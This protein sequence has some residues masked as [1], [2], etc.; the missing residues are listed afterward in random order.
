MQLADAAKDGL[1]DRVNA[2]EEKFTDPTIQGAI[3]TY[4]RPDQRGPVQRR[5]S[6]RRRSK[7]RAQ[8]CSPATRPWPC[9]STRSSASCS[10]WPTPPSWTRRSASSRSRRAATSARSSPTSPTRSSPSRPATPSVRPA[11]RQLLEL[12]ARRRLRGLR[13][14]AVDTVS[15]Q[16]GVE[17]PG[18]VPQALLDVSASLGDSVGS[19]QALAIANPDLYL[20]LGDMIQGTKT[21]VEVAQT[22]QDQF[23]QLAKAHRR[24]RLLIQHRGCRH[25][26]CRHPDPEGITHDHDSGTLRRRRP[27]AGIKESRPADAAGKTTRCGSCIPALAV[28]VVFFFVPTIFNFIYAFTEL[29]ELQVARS[30]SSALDNF[31]QL[32][33]NGTL[34][35][36][37]LDHPHLRDPRR[38]LP[39]RVRARPRPAA[40]TGHHAQPRS[41]ASRSSSPS[42]C[43]RSPSATSSRRCSSPTAP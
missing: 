33:S 3:D 1:W 31:V 15:L 43:P 34:L 40:G 13:Q 19:M 8:R 26:P 32:F 35:N 2:N 24:R 30:T 16:A 7:T 20:N 14:R 22:T 21:T 37:L 25:G 28:L 9:R 17:T 12:L 23:A 5:T 11:A 4:D 39:E 29:V 41:S 36:R 10:R 42:S 38:D 6:R 18:D 27:C